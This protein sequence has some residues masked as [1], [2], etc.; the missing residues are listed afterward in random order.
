MISVE[1][2]RVLFEKEKK[3]WMS[4][5]P[6]SD[7]IAGIVRGI[8]ICQAAVN[9]LHKEQRQYEPGVILRW[10]RSPLK[11]MNQAAKSAIRDIEHN[12]YGRAKATLKRNLREDEEFYGH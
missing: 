9:L 4:E 7:H 10:E 12:Q 1:R 3:R 5:I 2:L 11:R 8:K 6:Q